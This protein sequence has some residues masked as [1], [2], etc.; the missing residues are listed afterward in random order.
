[1][2]HE[3][4]LELLLNDLRKEYRACY[5]VCERI[6]K[7]YTNGV[8][9][10]KYLDLDNIFEYT[11]KKF[12][13]INIIYPTNRLLYQHPYEAIWVQDD[14]LYI[15]ADFAIILINQYTFLYTQPVWSVFLKKVIGMFKKDSINH[16]RF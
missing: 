4:R 8:V 10:L 13:T 14:N 6:S 7:H 5:V 12:K 3:R 2:N 1:M 9:L 16:L 15:T 11:Q